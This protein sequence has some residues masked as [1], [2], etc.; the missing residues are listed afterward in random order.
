M[1]DIKRWYVSSKYKGLLKLEIDGDSKKVIDYYIKK[2][3]ISSS[4]LLFMKDIWKI[5]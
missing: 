5:S 2:N 1:H 4:I 3:S